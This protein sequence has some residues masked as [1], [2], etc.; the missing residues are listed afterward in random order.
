MRRSSAKAATSASIEP[1]K[2]ADIIVVNGNPLFDIMA[3]S[4]VEIVVKD[5]TIFKG[6]PGAVRPPSTASIGK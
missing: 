5:G 3:L 1:G 6:G 2:I 4:H